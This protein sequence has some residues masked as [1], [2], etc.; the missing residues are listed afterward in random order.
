LGVAVSPDGSKVYITNQVDTAASTVSV[1]DTATN[2]ATATIPVGQEAAGIAVTP[3]GSKVYSVNARD[4]NVSVIATATNTVT[5]TIPVGLNP[6]AFGLFIQPAPR[7]AGTP[8]SSNCYGQSVAALVRQYGGLNAAATALGFSS[9]M[10]LQNTISA[11][12]GG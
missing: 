7:F 3:D 11:F 8:G 10:A 6:V 5:D 4:N 12:C 9:I 1:I 2:T